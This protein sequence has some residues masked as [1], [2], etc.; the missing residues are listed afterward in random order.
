MSRKGRTST[1]LELSVEP[2]NIFVV[3]NLTRYQ[4]AIRHLSCRWEP[5]K[6]VMLMN[7]ILLFDGNLGLFQLEDLLSH[8]VHLLQL[9]TD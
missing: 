6:L 4:Q 5:R 8:H 2:R 7:Y 3:P 1:S 9:S